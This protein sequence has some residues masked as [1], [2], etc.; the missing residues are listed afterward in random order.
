MFD[1][2]LGWWILAYNRRRLRAVG[3]KVPPDSM[4]PKVYCVNLYLMYVST[5]MYQLHVY[6]LS[7]RKFIPNVRV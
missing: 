4:S 1:T 6:S 5:T 2:R 3:M 7:W